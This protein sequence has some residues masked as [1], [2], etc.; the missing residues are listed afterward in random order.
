MIKVHYQDD[1]ASVLEACGGVMNHLINTERGVKSAASELIGKDVIEQ[2]RPPDD[3]FLIHSIAMGDQETYGPNKNADGWPKQALERRH[4]TFVTNGHFYRE[5]RNRD[6]KQKIG[7]I[8]YAAYKPVK[9][10]GMGRVELLKWGSKKLAEEE[11]ELAKAGKELCFSMSARVPEDVCSC[12]DK[13]SK[14]ASEY[15]DHLRFRALQYL[16][17]FRKYAYAVNPDPTFFDD[18]RVVRPADRIARFL[19]Y[20]FPD[21]D[22]RKAASSQRQVIMGA[23]WAEW[24]GVSIPDTYLP[25]GHEGRFLMKLAAEEAWMPEAD[26]NYGMSKKATFACAYAPFALMD[27]AT[28]EQLAQFRRL[29]PGTLF[30]ELAKRAC[31]MSFPTFAAYATGG[32]IESTKQDTAFL[33]AA[34]ELMPDMFS[35][36]A[37]CGCQADLLSTFSAD[38]EFSALCDPSASDVVQRVM[39]QA[40]RNFSIDAGPVADRVDRLMQRKAAGMFSDMTENEFDELTAKTASYTDLS[41]RAAALSESYAH[42][43]LAALADIERLR[44]AGSVDDPEITLVAGSNRRLIYR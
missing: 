12:C 29:R 37:A 15:C 33:H 2:H 19:D 13:H 7:D 9:D 28:D 20:K 30:R 1:Q 41:G 11:Y 23:E 38:N 44:G 27:D 25:D 43:Q 10:G 18:S 16:P 6:P 21:A 24:E 22:M 35:K 31:I 4:Q 17:E 5:H 32:D 42:Y 14:S 36:L 8:K 40:E 26:E 34:I 39:G 3:H